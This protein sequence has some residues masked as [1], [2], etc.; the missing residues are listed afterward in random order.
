MGQLLL[1]VLSIAMGCY[2]LVAYGRIL[3]A[4]KTY[5]VNSQVSQANQGIFTMGIVFIVSGIAFKLCDMSCGGNQQS[6]PLFS[7]SFLTFLLFLGIT[8]TALSAIIINKMPDGD[9][10]NWA[11][12][13]LVIGII[14]IVICGIKMGYNIYGKYRGGYSRMAPVQYGRALKS[15]SPVQYGQM[16]RTGGVGRSLAF[17]AY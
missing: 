4:T 5:A 17:S 2:L 9:G 6:S 16:P 15:A 12:I 3:E 13:T 7:N 10:K 14:F 1:T 8:L 11:I